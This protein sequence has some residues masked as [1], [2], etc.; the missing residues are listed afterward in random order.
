[1]SDACVLPV[2]TARAAASAATALTPAPLQ[3]TGGSPGL[4][5]LVFVALMV[6]TGL[7]V[8]VAIRLYRGY[9]QGGGTGM[10]LLGVGL[11]LLATAPMVLRLVLTNVPGVGATWREIVATA[12]QLLGLLVI[13]GVIYGRR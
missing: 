8:Y 5:A 2:A 9:R 4:V 11:V 1:M 7:S 3:T 6:A 10:L 13:L 12:S